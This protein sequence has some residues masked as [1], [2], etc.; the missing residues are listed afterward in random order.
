MIQFSRCFEYG[1][2]LTSLLMF[3]EE[4]LVLVLY[5]HFPISLPQVSTSDFPFPVMED[6]RVSARI[7]EASV[8]GGLFSAGASSQRGG[9]AIEVMLEQ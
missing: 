2:A 4:H 8:V 5:P 3:L 6:P 7:L 9:S 1:D